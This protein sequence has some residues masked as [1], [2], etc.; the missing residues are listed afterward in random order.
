[1]LLNIYSSGITQGKK[2]LK[3]LGDN[4]VAEVFV[5]TVNLWLN[6]QSPEQSVSAEY[7]ILEV[8]LSVIPITTNDF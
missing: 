8:L 4:L 6:I 1:M 2:H 5:S 3:G 7:A